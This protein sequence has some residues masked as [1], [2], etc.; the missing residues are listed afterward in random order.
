[1]VPGI[2]SEVPAFR[3]RLSFLPLVKAWEQIAA[4]EDRSAKICSDLMRQFVKNAEL[5][6]PI[7]E[8]VLLDKHQHLIEEAMRTIFPVSLNL[9][10]QLTAITTPFSN[11][12]IYASSHFRHSFMD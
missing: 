9:Q 2:Y 3:S 10:K 7:D 5:L 6:E 4:S 11:K 12:V 1:M 8:Y